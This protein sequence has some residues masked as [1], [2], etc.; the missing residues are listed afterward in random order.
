M[1][2]RLEYRLIKNKPEFG[3][4][5]QYYY[6][7][8]LEEWY[9]QTGLE[10]LSIGDDLYTLQDNV[11]YGDTSQT[12]ITI[13]GSD[14]SSIIEN[15]PLRLSHI[16]NSGQSQDDNT[17]YPT[18]D[19]RFVSNVYTGNNYETGVYLQKYHELGSID[20]IQTSAPIFSIHP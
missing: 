1:A 11:F 3:S 7:T 18:Q 17:E 6:N 9:Y 13:L 19:F 15:D 5:A 12:Y 20:Y 14:N 8:E 16:Y 4:N 2:G 10:S